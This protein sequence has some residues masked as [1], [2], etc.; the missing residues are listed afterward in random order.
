MTAA[1]K[2]LDAKGR[3][4][5]SQPFATGRNGLNLLLAPL[6][7]DDG[8]FPGDN[9]PWQ[10]SL[11]ATIARHVPGAQRRSV[12]L[13]GQCFDAVDFHP[14][15]QPGLRNLLL[16]AFDYIAQESMFNSL[17][18]RGKVHFERQ[19]I[20]RTWS[21]TWVRLM[22]LD[23]LPVAL[24]SV[25]LN[26]A[27]LPLT[28]AARV[29][30]EAAQCLDFRDA[31]G[32]KARL[33][34]ATQ[35]MVPYLLAH[36]GFVT[37]PRF[38]IGVTCA[39][40]V[41]QQVFSKLDREGPKTPQ[42]DDNGHL[43]A[44]PTARYVVAH[45]DKVAAIHANA[46]NLDRIAGTRPRQRLDTSRHEQAPAGARGG[47]AARANRL[48]WRFKTR[49]STLEVGD[50]IAGPEAAY[51]AGIEPE[52]LQQALFIDA[53]ESITPEDE[54]AAGLFNVRAGVDRSY[55][56]PETAYASATT[57][58]GKEYAVIPSSQQKLASFAALEKLCGDTLGKRGI[59]V[60][61][62]YTP[63][64]WKKVHWL[65]RI[66]YRYTAQLND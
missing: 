12:W 28:L 64:L 60:A 58:T 9:K 18:S 3:L 49:R 11:V 19:I 23:G 56:T 7:D 15:A 39:Y 17:N 35:V 24:F 45:S 65:L 14:P 5:T 63:K 33:K 21:A 55:A 46:A 48:L 29:D 32:T 2:L 57:E 51:Y 8:C 61:G 42:L 59:Y 30:D 27:R 16:F 10:G 43:T 62:A 66:R 36:S 34:D 54:R 22:D 50:S 52:D 40:E 6:L 53:F 38:G 20:G 44:A 4:Q 41:T 25:D 1:A 47:F 13:R 37:R 26:A 31:T